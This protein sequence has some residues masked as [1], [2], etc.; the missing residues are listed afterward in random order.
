MKKLRSFVAVLVAAFSARDGFGKPWWCLRTFRWTRAA[1]RK[2]SHQDMS[3][4]PY[5]LS[6]FLSHRSCRW[7]AGAAVETE[8]L[9]VHRCELLLN[10]HT[11]PIICASVV[12]YSTSKRCLVIMSDHACYVICN[13][14][15]VMP[16]LACR[17]GLKKHTGIWWQDF[18]VHDG[19]FFD[20][21]QAISPQSHRCNANTFVDLVQEIAVAI[22]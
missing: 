11:C 20:I 14:L 8:N 19:F 10:D 3:A 21:C 13:K 2:D 22:V 15:I 1:L 12:C 4:Y 7:S 16:L 9:E 18:I 17:N 6:C 5:P